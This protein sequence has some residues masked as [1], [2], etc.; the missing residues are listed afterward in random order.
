MPAVKTLE[1]RGRMLA[2]ALFAQ[3]V[4]AYRGGV[5]TGAILDAF[6]A[7][8][9]ELNE[10]QFQGSPNIAEY[11]E[12]YKKSVDDVKSWRISKADFEF[13]RTLARGQFGIVDIVRSKHTK[14][15][16]AMKTL[17]KQ[18][19]LSQREQ[20]AFLEERDVLVLGKDSPWIPDL[21]ASFQDKEHLYI[22]MEFVAG[23]D[24]FSMLDRCE[25]AVID[26]DAA[27]F[28]AAELVLALE[29]LHKI[30]YIHRDCKPQNTL[31]D[32]RGHVKLADFGSC[33]RIDASGAHEAKTSVPVGTCDYIAPETLRARE[34][35]GGGVV[36]TSCDWW[37]LGT[38][39]YEML[40]G[41][42]PFYSD[43]VPETYGKIMSSDKHLAFDID[44]PVSDAAKDLM[45]RLLVRQEDRLG[46]AGIK[47]HP[48]FAG[49]DWATIRSQ[50]APFVPRI[51][52]PD[53]TS[54]FSVGDEA[55]EDIGMAMARASSS[56]LGHG[57]EYAGEQLPFIG[58][59]HLPQAFAQ[60]TRRLA[61]GTPR[62]PRD[63]PSQV[64]A[65]R[66]KIEQLEAADAKWRAL[67]T[68][69]DEER[70]RMA[71]ERKGLELRIATLEAEAMQPPP[72]APSPVRPAKRDSAMQ[73]EPMHAESP[74]QEPA[75]AV[76]T[77]EEKEKED[78]PT[79]RG[80]SDAGGSAYRGLV[81][82]L[83]QQFEGQAAQ[84]GTLIAAVNGLAA[85]TSEKLDEGIMMQKKEFGALAQA[86]HQH[87]S[88]TATAIPSP[89]LQAQQNHQAPP[90][91]LSSPLLTSKNSLSQMYQ[92]GASGSP[93]RLSIGPN[94][95]TLRGSRRSISAVDDPS[96]LDSHPKSVVATLV[97]EMSRSSGDQGSRQSL[98]VSPAAAN[99]V[100]RAERRV[101]AGVASDALSVIGNKCDR[102]AALFE[103]YSGEIEG[104][105]RSQ[106]SLVAICS[107]LQAAIAKNDDVGR[108]LADI[109]ETPTPEGSRRGRRKTEQM[110]RRGPDLFG[111]PMSPAPVDTAAIDLYK[112]AADEVV[113][114]LKTQVTNA[115]AARVAAEARAAELLSWIGRESK[116]RA[117]LEDMIRTA[118]QACKMAEEK[119]DSMISETESLKKTLA[120]RDEEV[121]GLQATIETRDKELRHLRRASRKA[122]DQLADLKTTQQQQQQPPL[123]SEKTKENLD[124]ELQEAAAVH[125]RLQFEIARLEGEISRLESEKAQLAK[126]L[127]LKD[128]RLKAAE[129]KASKI[130]PASDG[131]RVRPMD[132]G[133]AEEEEEGNRYGSVGTKS[134]KRFKVQLQNMQKHIEYL[135]TKLALSVSENDQLRRQN[136]AGGSGG[137]HGIRIPGFSRSSSSSNNHNNVNANANAN[138]NADGGTRA[139]GSS[140]SGSS[141]TIHDGT[142][143]YGNRHASGGGSASGRENGGT[144]GP[145]GPRTRP[146]STM[147]PNLQSNMASAF[148]STVSLNL[149]GHKSGESLDAAGGNHHHHHPTSSR[150][151]VPTEPMGG[152]SSS[153]TRP[154]N[155]SLTSSFERMRSPF[156]GFRKHF[157]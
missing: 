150:R 93:A 119:L 90:G 142:H 77:E 129:A 132:G 18:A 33:A 135:E 147:F 55:D 61:Q 47:A 76:A 4:L 101:S 66:T 127:S 60:S 31:L 143:G 70:L 75:A 156:K 74:L 133:I 152:G 88:G 114:G 44:V 99:R 105:H 100:S 112:A 95:Q 107:A 89:A 20:A 149:D 104:I 131:I 81:S 42:P 67:Q 125:V 38:V 84:L 68:E 145:A 6:V 92:T 126:E 103:Q 116:G 46:L 123:P 39:L 30:G 36:S 13:V 113:A 21:Y 3:D 37:S 83:A 111:R 9:E 148:A 157:S 141:A 78:T 48:F 40:Y 98:A 19:L 128:A 154:R 23:G 144:N 17:N 57:R 35:G 25:N 109:P 73:T 11:V 138:A 121:A 110:R 10:R 106:A 12:R 65:L 5:D 32:E 155:D 58:F 28:Y 153:T 140:G 54:N 2:D 50:D 87:A 8:H 71:A 26:E 22:V 118:Q 117:L 62:G 102:L 43:S 7:L 130:D 134:H 79:T 108:S 115:E 52:S 139:N 137:S 91:V 80:I 56:R 53:D 14:A 49:V 122:L 29:D 1:D 120:A 94:T 64:R 146:L 82:S 97:N 45:R 85:A 15:V 63:D 27:R 24:L 124:A 51:S 69:W 16:Y 151:R 34:L 72:R 41:D 86:L 59:T 136:Q 96:A